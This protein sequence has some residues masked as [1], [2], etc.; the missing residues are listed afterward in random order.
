MSRMAGR[1]LDARGLPEGYPL[2]ADWEITP[3][4]VR[5]L[6]AAGERFV[7]ID[8]REPAEVAAASLEGAVCVPVG[9]IKS[10]LS[11]LD[12][13]ADDR[14]VV[15]CHLGGRSMQVVAFLRQQGFSDVVSMAGGID[16]WARDIDAHV[17]RY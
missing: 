14:V 11:E 13:H 10:R 3:R 15:M 8:V 12:E 1:P 4:Q 6:R 5:A 7:L 17:P 16:L 9:E 2:Q